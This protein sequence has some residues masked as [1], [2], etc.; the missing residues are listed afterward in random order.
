MATIYARLLNQYKFKYHKLF[1]SSFHKSNEQDQRS[2][3]IDFFI[4]LNISHYLTESDINNIDV[5]SPL[6]HQIR[7]LESKRKWLDIL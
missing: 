3:E 7:I 6:E 1:S 5:K 2:D 4:K